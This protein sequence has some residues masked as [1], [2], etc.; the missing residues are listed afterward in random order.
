MKKLVKRV[1]FWFFSVIICG[2]FVGLMGNRIYYRYFERTNLAY[3][4]D[5]FR[6]AYRDT[7]LKK[8]LKITINGKNVNEL[9][10]TT[11]S[12]INDGNTT[13]TRDDFRDESDPVR[14]SGRH[15]ESV[16]IDKIN[17]TANSRVKLI[18][19]RGGVKI[20]F[21]W[22]NPH[23]RIVLKVVHHR[24][25]DNIQL[26]GSFRGVSRI[27]RIDTSASASCARVGLLRSVFTGIAGVL[28]GVIMTIGAGYLIKTVKNRS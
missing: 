11:I 4:V 15:I 22:L 14:I 26:H 12:L 9:Y 17:T 3:T 21:K 25:G 6:M 2:I 10:I 18:K 5:T 19:S 8:K 1:L 16:F 13:L 20:N 23:D 24:P 28:L 7:N 27:S